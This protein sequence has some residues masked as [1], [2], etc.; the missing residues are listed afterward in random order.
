MLVELYA[1]AQM[2]FSSARIAV[3]DSGAAQSGPGRVVRYQFPLETL[4]T[5]SLCQRFL[6]F[7]AGSQYRFRENAVHFRRRLPG[8]T[9]MPEYLF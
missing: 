1:Y 9:L 7:D 2:D 5:L 3:G 4:V 6:G 8:T